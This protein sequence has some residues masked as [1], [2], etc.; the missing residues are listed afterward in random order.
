MHGEFDPSRFN[1]AWIEVLAL[2]DVSLRLGVE[3]MGPTKTAAPIQSGSLDVY[4]VLA[5]TRQRVAFDLRALPAGLTEIHTLRILGR[6]LDPD[7]VLISVE[8]AQRAPRAWLPLRRGVAAHRAPWSSG[9]SCALRAR[10]SARAA[11]A[12]A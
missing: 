9:T 3:G 6:G 2:E 4:F 1:L 5:G 7:W 10:P 11:S 12:R 8:L